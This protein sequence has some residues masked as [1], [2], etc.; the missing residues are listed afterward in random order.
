[1]HFKK[2]PVEDVLKRSWSGHR[3][4]GKGALSGVGRVE[5]RGEGRR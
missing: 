3:E 1:M 4:A 2:I 5:G